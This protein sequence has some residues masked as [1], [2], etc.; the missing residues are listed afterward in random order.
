[1]VACSTVAC[2]MVAGYGLL[3]KESVDNFAGNL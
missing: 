1:M 2:F 3:E